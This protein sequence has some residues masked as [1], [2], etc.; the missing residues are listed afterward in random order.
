LPR[1][2][3]IDPPFVRFAKLIRGSWFAKVMVMSEHVM[4]EH[5][6]SEH[7]MSER[8]MSQSS[9]RT[10]LQEEDLAHS[11]EENNA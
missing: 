3:G 7:V 4:S 5:V 8:V 2:A 11:K 6:M 10:P 1:S 9:P